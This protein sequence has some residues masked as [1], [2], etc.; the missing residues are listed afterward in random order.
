MSRPPRF[1][2]MTAARRVLVAGALVAAGLTCAGVATVAGAATTS[3]SKPPAYWLVASDGGIFAFGGAGFYGSTGSMQLNKPVVGMAGTAD[4]GGYW[5]VA[6]DGGIFTFGDAQF[7]GS[8]GAM[9]LVKPV[10]GMAA[11]PTGGGY[12]LVAADGGIFTFGNA[13]F[14]G[15]M[16]SRPLNQPIVGMAATP[17]GAG[18]WLVASDGGIFAFGDAAF[19]GS[20]GGIHLNKP[21]VGMTSTPDG[22]G[23]WFTASDGGVFAYGDANFYGS[24]GGVP[25]KYPIVAMAG[26]TAG[27]G[28]WFT[29][30]N[31]GV[32]AYGTAPFWGSAPQVLNKPIV[33]MAGAVGSGQFSFSTYPSA[34]YG[35]DISN[36]QCAHMPPSPHTIGVVEVVGVSFGAANRCLKTEATWAAGGL[37]LYV[38]LTYGTMTSSGDAACQSAATPFACNDGFNAALDAFTKAQQAGVNT[39]VGWW[40]DVER[41]PQSL[42]QWSSTTKANASLIQGAIDG[43]HY[44]GINSV[45]VYASPAVWSTIVGTYQPAVPYWAAD[46]ELNP[47]TTCQNIHTKYKVLPAG[48]VAMVQYSSPTAVYPAGGMTTGF[49]NDY[50]C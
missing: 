2:A 42:P 15:S 28:Y 45:G 34:S 3:A 1:A 33:G 49:D 36:F 6:S 25:Q 39:A 9:A 7:Y 43:L 4:S 38:F 26:T 40:L 18:Y 48:P 32:T 10:V 8:T 47:A 16:G 23:Y 19:Y 44:A 11:T 17:D 20:T 24:L 12:W 22:L 41:P 35:Y 46:W 50:A 21:I 37:N 30:S 13:Q 27:T 29:N 14:Y 5:L 31:G